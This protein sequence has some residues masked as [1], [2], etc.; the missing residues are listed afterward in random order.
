MG[1][2][3]SIWNGELS[4]EHLRKSLWSRGKLCL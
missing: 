1:R 3:C 4:K 2:I